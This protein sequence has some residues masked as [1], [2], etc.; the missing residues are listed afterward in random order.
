MSLGIDTNVLLR[1]FINDGSAQFD[2]VAELVREQDI[3]IPP[4]VLLETEW[5]L[6]DVFKLAGT[7]SRMPSNRSSAPLM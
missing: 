5:V 6:R 1:S 2:A 4:T 3:L 7:R